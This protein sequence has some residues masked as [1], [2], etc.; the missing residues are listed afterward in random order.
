[1]NP[2]R[3][4][5]TN[6]I[7]GFLGVGKTTAILHLLR[8][9]PEHE[10]WAVLVNEFGEIGIDGAI[11]EQ[12]GA[13]VREIPGGCMCCV[14]GLPLQVGLNQLLATRPDRL[15]IEPTGLGHP[16][17]IVE[18][19]SGPQYFDTLDLRATVC[20]VDA[21]KVADPRYRDHTTFRDQLQWAD[22]VIANK[23]AQSDAE[24]RRRL[25]AFLQKLDPPQNVAAWVDQGA[26]APALL[27]GPRR[28]GDR[29]AHGHHHAERE[30]PLLPAQLEPG[31]VFLRRENTG[32][33]H[34][35]CGWLFAAGARFGFAQLFALCSG[36]P[37]DRLKAVLNTERGTFIFNA[38]G[39]V[40]S[41][42]DG[43][44]S[45]GDSRVEV[46]HRTALNWDLLERDL[47]AALLTAS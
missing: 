27:D 26:L 16:R 11:L 39:G 5:P 32:L 20:L 38:E 17:N 3:H 42:L 1:M 33:D 31:Q 6:I 8:Q 15:L 7:S 19:L 25:E 2:V 46:I 41:V 35:S 21:R 28:R 40:L 47:R 24:D 10:R 9:K 44:G 45:G 18:L 14:A 43:G 36:L 12:G 23:N 13:S 29:H 4:V 22:A 30:Q 37:V 34:A